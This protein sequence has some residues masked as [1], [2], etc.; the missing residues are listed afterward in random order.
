[1]Q[2]NRGLNRPV[3]VELDDERDSFVYLYDRRYGAAAGP[4]A[5]VLGYLN[6]MNGR[7]FFCISAT[8]IF[9]NAKLSGTI[10]YRLYLY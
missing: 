7:F 8:I 2:P 1:M 3:F 5:E 9:P 10:L 4:E 6:E